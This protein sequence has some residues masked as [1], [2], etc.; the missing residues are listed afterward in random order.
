MAYDEAGDDGLTAAERLR[1]SEAAYMEQLQRQEEATAA[2]ERAQ[3]RIELRHMR[4]QEMVQCSFND[5]FWGLDF[6]LYEQEREEW[7]RQC[8]GW[9]DELT[10]ALRQEM[11]RKVRARALSRSAAA[12]AVLGFALRIGPWCR[13]SC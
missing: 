2:K 10:D 9:E 13:C 7:E 3:Q 12:V 8:M 11:R 1:Q 5:R 4:A 6:R